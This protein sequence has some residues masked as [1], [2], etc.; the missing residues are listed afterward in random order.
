MLQQ[1]T[2]RRTPISLMAPARLK[3]RRYVL[4]LGRLVPEKRPDLLIKA[5]QALKPLDGNLFLSVAPVIQIFHVTD[6]QQLIQMYFTGELQIF[7]GDR[8][9]SGLLYL[10]WGLPLAML[11]AMRVY[12]C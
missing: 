2:R 1:A 5:F 12:R 10:I 3:A 8:S 6:N 4:F 9:G 7:S 11:E